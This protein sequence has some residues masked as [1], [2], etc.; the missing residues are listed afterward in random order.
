[1]MA[2]LM[3]VPYREVT[4]YRAV[5]ENNLPY[6]TKHGVKGDEF[7]NVLVLL[8]D[9]GANW[10]QYSFGNL[11]AGADKSESRLLRTRNLFYVCCSRAKK[12]L[13]I[14]DLGSPAGKEKAIEA[15]FGAE[16]VV[17]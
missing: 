2:K 13:V 7:D 1:M 14:A 15:L 17:L 9:A 10:N 8:D 16:S 12:N 6:S 11:L 4:N 3:S 5:L